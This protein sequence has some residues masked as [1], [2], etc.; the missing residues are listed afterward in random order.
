[1]K[2]TKIYIESK[3]TKNYQSQTVGIEVTI[4]NDNNKEEL[5]KDLQKQTNKLALN[6]LEELR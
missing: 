6:A 1:M 4:K 5:I 2:I 3:R